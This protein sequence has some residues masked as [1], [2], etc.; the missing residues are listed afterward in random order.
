[1][2]TSKFQ[3]SRVEC[4]GAKPWIL[5]RINKREY[6]ISLEDFALSLTGKVVEATTPDEITKTKPRKKKK[7]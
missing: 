3:I 5:V 4:D 7:K 6:H 1:M 2:K